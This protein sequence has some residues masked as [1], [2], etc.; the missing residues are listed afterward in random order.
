MK[1]GTLRGIGCGI[2]LLAAGCATE[3][4]NTPQA[5]SDRVSLTLDVATTRGNENPELP[6]AEKIHTLRVIIVDGKGE[7][8]HNALI[9][10]NDAGGVEEV[11]ARTFEV[12]KNDTKTIYL[13]ANAEQLPGLN[14]DESEG[15][16]TRITEY[17]GVTVEYLRNADWL[18]MSSSYSFSVQDKNKDC[19]TLYVAYAATKFT[20]TFENRMPAGTSLGVSGITV[21][22]IAT[23]SYLHPR[24][25]KRWLSD[26]LGRRIVSEYE[27]PA[28]ATHEPF[29]WEGFD[30]EVIES[31]ASC[32]FPPLYLTE[33]RNINDVD[34]TQSYSVGLKIGTGA[35]ADDDHIRDIQL[36]D[37][38]N[39]LNAL[40]RCT[41]VNVKVI[42]KSLEQIEIITGIYAMIEPW[43]EL[44]PV[45][46][47]IVEKQ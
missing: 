47:S 41:H 38:T 28:H 16:Q 43:E 6:D 8:E 26:L 12:S 17:D 13:L 10:N 15:L 30:R 20:F 35:S 21:N 19:E 14:P 46:G 37:G 39:P 45:S 40:F 34:L 24:A 2:L 5:S 22:Q 29:V 36:T 7:V 18:P 9:Y 27:I 23:S 11:A 32:S 4:D 44:D 3:E 42:V 25:S 33:S 1:T 31:G